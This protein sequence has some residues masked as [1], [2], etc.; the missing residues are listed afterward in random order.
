LLYFVYS[1]SIG[2]F[3]VA[4]LLAIVDW[5]VLHTTVTIH[6]LPFCSSF[7]CLTNDF[8]RAYWGL[9]NMV[10]NLLSCLF[11]VAV[12]YKLCRSSKSTLLVDEIE[13][14]NKHKIDRQ[15]NRVSL[16]ILLVS[17]LMGV[18]PGCLNGVGTIIKFPLLEEVA[19]FVGTCATLSGLSHAFIFAMA[20]RDIK[21]CILMKIFRRHSVKRV[22]RASNA[23]S[24]H[25]HMAVVN[26]PM[27]LQVPPRSSGRSA[28]CP[29][30]GSRPFSIQRQP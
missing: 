17:A 16:Y 22:E 5:L 25:F 23:T 20:H 27:S 14:Q 15:A 4:I 19:F 9:S 29:P 6:R 30:L 13:R 8:F 26:T 21:E 24:H 18:V 3:I 10:M 7:G 1:W 12:M 11:T 28:S 2:A